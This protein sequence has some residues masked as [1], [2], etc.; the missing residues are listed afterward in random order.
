ML[1][2]F[3]FLF[4]VVGLGLG[5]FCGRFS[6]P[7]S[8]LIDRRLN[9]IDSTRLVSHST[10][11]ILK[12]DNRKR[13]REGGM[14]ESVELVPSTRRLHCGDSTSRRNASELLRN[15][16]IRSKKMETSTRVESSRI[17]WMSVQLTRLHCVYAPV[18]S[19][20]SIT[21]LF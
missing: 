10:T 14:G 4:F 11:R 13:N 18:C 3:S 9:R 16:S 6:F 8:P 21:V 19:C 2:F 20:S 1:L 5:Q 17:V 7:S 15:P 12:S